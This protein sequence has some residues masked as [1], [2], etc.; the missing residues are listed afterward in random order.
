MVGGERKP[1]QVLITRIW[2]Y[3]AGLYGRRGGCRGRNRL[4][5][6][7]LAKIEREG[8]AHAQQR[9]EQNGD[10]DIEQRPERPATARRVWD[11]QAV[12]VVRSDF[13]RHVRPQLVLLR[14]FGALV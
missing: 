2:V 4:R 3:T 11:K 8:S 1:P 14:R 7:L 10:Y 9:Y 12:P 13:T 6:A 5:D